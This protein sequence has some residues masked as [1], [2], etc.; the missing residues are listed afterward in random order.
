[1]QCKRERS[2]VKDLD[3]V[4]NANKLFGGILTRREIKTTK[5]NQQSTKFSDQ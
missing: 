1:M 4:V 3:F 2:A 5:T